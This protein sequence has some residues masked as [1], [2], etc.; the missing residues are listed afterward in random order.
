MPPFPSCATP[1]FYNAIPPTHYTRELRHNG[2]M[3]RADFLKQVLSWQPAL[4]IQKF[5]SSKNVGICCLMDT[6]L[7]YQVFDMPTCQ[8][9]S[10]LAN[11]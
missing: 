9:Q 1:T 3:D 10:Q 2:Y 6:S 5:G 8:Q 4:V 7:T 11:P